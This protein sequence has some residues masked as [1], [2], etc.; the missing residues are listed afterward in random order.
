MVTVKRHYLY[1]KLRTLHFKRIDLQKD[2]MVNFSTE[3]G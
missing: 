2:E 3:L 1:E